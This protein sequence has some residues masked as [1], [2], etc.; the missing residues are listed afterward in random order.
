MVETEGFRFRGGRG[1]GCAIPYASNAL[2]YCSFAWR[3]LLLTRLLG[4]PGGGLALWIQEQ[5]AALR[6]I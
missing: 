6:W 1:Y 3:M 2:R 5:A 4:M